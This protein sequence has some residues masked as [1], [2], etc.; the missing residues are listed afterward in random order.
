[1]PRKDPIIEEV[2]SVREDIARAAD[3]N[4]EKMLEAARERQAA[5]GVQAVRLPPRKAEPVKT[6]IP[7]RNRGLDRRSDASRER[8]GA[9][10]G[11]MAARPVQISMDPDLLDQIDADPEAREKGRSAFIRSAVQLYLKAKER[12]DIDARLAP[13]YAGEAGSLVEEVEGLMDK[14]SWPND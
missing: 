2:H 12:R 4:L 8:Q 6:R 14:Q 11:T 9:G 7:C 5:S 13:A 10:G 3:Y 1:M